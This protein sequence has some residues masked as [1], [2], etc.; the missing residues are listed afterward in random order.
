MGHED[1][2]NGEGIDGGTRSHWMRVQEWTE[3]RSGFDVGDTAHWGLEGS[4]L[5]S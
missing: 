3:K 5:E 2:R 1:A 4:M